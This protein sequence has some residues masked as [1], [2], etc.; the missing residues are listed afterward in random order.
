[1][2]QDEVNGAVI[3]A[4]IESRAAALQRE[5]ALHKEIARLQAEIVKLRAETEPSE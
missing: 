1:M 4:L 3:C 5:Q 2:T